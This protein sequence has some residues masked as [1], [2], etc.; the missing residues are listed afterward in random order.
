MRILSTV[1]KSYVG[2]PEA[3]EPMFLEFTLPLKRMGHEVEHF[4]HMKE[5]AAFGLDEAGA[6]FE[7]L[8]R[9]GHFDLVLYQTAGR[10]F[11]NR[12][13]IAEA[14]RHAPVVAWNSDD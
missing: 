2:H 5:S 6:R 1:G 4:D 12:A 8:V 13:A 14:A 11:M 7:R 3:V 9:Y 10:D